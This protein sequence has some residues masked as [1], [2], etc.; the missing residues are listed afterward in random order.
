MRIRIGYLTWLNVKVVMFLVTLESWSFILSG[1]Q[2]KGSSNDLGF[3]RSKCL[4]NAKLWQ[5]LMETCMVEMKS[6]AAVYDM[7]IIF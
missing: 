1:T 7:T 4:E 3:P 6:T 5:R 2:A